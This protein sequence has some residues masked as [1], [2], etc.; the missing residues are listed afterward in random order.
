MDG[1][2]VLH[3]KYGQ[4]VVKNSRHKGF[5]LQVTFEDGLTRWVRS[6]ELIEK[7][8]KAPISSSKPDFSPVITSDVNFKSR[9][10]IESFRLGIVPDDC[11]E[12]FTFGRED[13]TRCVMD[14]LNSSEESVLLV[15][16]GYGTGKSHLLNYARGCALK[17]GFAVAYIETDPN[18]SPFHKPKRIYGRLAKTLRFVSLY[19]KQ[20]RGFRDFLKEAIA[21]GAFEDHIYFKH[22]IG[23]SSDENLWNWIEAVESNIRPWCEYPNSDKYAWLPALYDSQISANIYCYLLSAL[24]W[25]ARKMLNLKGMLLIFDEAES[26]G[27]Y[28]YNYQFGKG[29]NYVKALIRTADDYDDLL[30]SPRK[31][32][33]DYSRMGDSFRTPFL[34]RQPSSLKLLFAFTNTHVLQPVSEL[35]T[36][37]RIDLKPLEDEVLYDVFEHIC[38][39]YGYAYDFI[40][41]DPIIDSIFQRVANQGGRTRFFVKGSVEALDLARLSHDEFRMKYSHG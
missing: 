17:A 18:E 6:D 1:R 9:R 31:T 26:I 39:H 40:E 32:G 20:I 7:R 2:I 33:L 13:E 29:C 37:T 11:V 38:L 24:G 36:A 30:S 14:W 34:Y 4:G 41:E 35:R 28:Y 23:K 22:L 27:M 21:N 8:I 3:S 12:E 10:M 25:A 16:G 5:E 19:N 15:I